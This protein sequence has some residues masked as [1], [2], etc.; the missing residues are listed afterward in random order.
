MDDQEHAARRET[1]EAAVWRITG[2]RG[3]PEAVDELLGAVD[4][5]VGAVVDAKL[6]TERAERRAEELAAAEE[7]VAEFEA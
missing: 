2:W 6:A 3:E 4:T 5:Y 1:L 7:Y